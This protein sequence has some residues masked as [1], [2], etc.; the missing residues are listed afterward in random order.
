[1]LAP[2]GREM[3]PPK[4][5][6]FTAHFLDSAPD[7]G[8]CAGSFAPA[9]GLADEAFGNVNIAVADIGRPMY[10]AGWNVVK[11][12]EPLICGDKAVKP[13]AFEMIR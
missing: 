6:V 3:H 12:R 10:V 13:S 9:Q 2:T 11:I 4:S 7:T 5:S 1:M 8:V